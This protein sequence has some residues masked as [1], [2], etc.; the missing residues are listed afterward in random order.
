MVLAR[1]MILCH[2][3]SYFILENSAKILLLKLIVL[4][5]VCFTIFFAVD[6]VVGLLW[7]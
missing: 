4:E 2:D 3:L 6:P 5:V 7:S 1:V